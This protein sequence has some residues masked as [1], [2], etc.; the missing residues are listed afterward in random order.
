MKTAE[1]ARK[2]TEAVIKLKES[3]AKIHPYT[4]VREKRC[5]KDNLGVISKEINLAIARG[6]GCVYVS[7]NQLRFR[8]NILRGQQVGLILNKLVGF[9]Y[10]VSFH[11]SE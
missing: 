3:G 9:G 6:S 4:R 5:K 10:G 11:N 1:Q 8:K 7:A 2:E